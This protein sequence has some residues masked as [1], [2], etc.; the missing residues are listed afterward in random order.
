MVW[1][2]VELVQW[3]EHES[4]LLGDRQ[5]A[6]WMVVEGSS[7]KNTEQGCPDDWSKDCNI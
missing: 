6:G 5:L 3:Q 7:N 2:V 1:M 4:K